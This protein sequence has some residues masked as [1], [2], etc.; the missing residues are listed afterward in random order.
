MSVNSGGEPDR[1]DSGLPPVDIEIPDDARDLD[2]DVQAYYREQR[3]WRRRQRRRRLTGPLTRDGIVLPLLACC[4]ILALITGTL[5]TVFTATGENQAGLQPPGSAAGPHRAGSASPGTKP[6]GS[7]S[8]GV[9]SIGGGVVPDIVT[10]AGL[11]NASLTASGHAIPLRGLAG[12]VLLLIPANCNCART[13]ARL[14]QMAGAISAGVYLIGTGSNANAIRQFATQLG[15][16]L[17]ATTRVATGA[18]GVLAQRYHPAGLTAI[19][20]SADHS[21]STA[22][23]LTAAD[24]MTPLVQVLTR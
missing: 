9:P 11:P 16:S 8:T 7:P 23:G 12:A 10:A 20:V 15:P 4:L 17:G 6:S 1:G 21:V 18:G 5:L 22:K 14:S 3:A 13:V 24:N 2:R 19:L